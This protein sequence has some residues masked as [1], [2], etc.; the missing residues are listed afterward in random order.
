M[1]AGLSALA[2]C[3][4]ASLP[5]SAQQ[6][7]VE[8]AKKLANPIGSLISVPFQHNYDH[9]LGLDDKGQRVTMNA[10]PVVPFSVSDD[11]NIISR[12]ILPLTWQEGVVPGEGT[13][14]GLGD[15]VQSL[16]LSPKETGDHGI[17]WG[18]GPVALLPTATED[19]LGSEKLGLGPTAVALT[20]SGPWT[21][22]VLS[23]HIWSVAGEGA[24]RDVNTSFVQPIVSYTTK[25][26]TTFSLV[27]EIA[28]DWERE[29]ASIPVIG[30][31]NQ[32]FTVGE[33][34]M[35]LGAGVRY[36]AESPDAGP[37]GFGAR[38][39]LVFLFPR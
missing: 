19:T 10:Q 27:S 30:V 5:A 12:T 37:E 14:F 24:R 18:V 38:I 7:D 22:G 2:I 36:W 28:Y 17:I 20:Q 3:I 1:K 4:A 33:Q 13:Q 23:N 16:F 9:N 26:A 35:Q 32:L 6:T 29:Q 15:T 31:V 39:N 34:T 21:V 25:G 8:L 11:W